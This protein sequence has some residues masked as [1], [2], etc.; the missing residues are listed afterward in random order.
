[1]SVLP[2][3]L[4]PLIALRPFN[5]HRRAALSMD[6]A[7]TWRARTQTVMAV[8]RLFSS[9]TRTAPWTGAYLVYDRALSM[10]LFLRTI[11]SLEL[12][13]THGAVNPPPS[14]KASNAHS[15]SALP[16]PRSPRRTRTNTTMAASTSFRRL[17]SQVSLASVRHLARSPSLLL[18][19]W[20]ASHL[21][22]NQ[23]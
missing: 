18:L 19:R 2:R 4:T 21:S 17:S 10:K 13:H 20:R 12:H 9:I 11:T 1:M 5:G 23:L 7:L 8:K 6:L 15:R 14:A 3:T 16:T 22:A